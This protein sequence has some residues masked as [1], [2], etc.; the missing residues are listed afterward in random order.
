MTDKYI[1]PDEI[2]TGFNKRG[3]TLNGLLGFMIYRN[4]PDGSYGLEKSFSGWVDKKIPEKFISNNFQT[5][6]VINKGHK[7][8]HYYGNTV[9]IRVYHPEGFEFEIPLDNLAM[10][11]HN[12]TVEKSNIIDKCVVAWYGNNVFLIPEIMKNEV[13]FKNMV[14]AQEKETARKFIP[15]AKCEPAN[16]YETENGVEFNIG[17]I[18]GVLARKVNG[19]IMISPNTG[20]Q[21]SLPVS[22]FDEIDNPMKKLPNLYLK[23]KKLRKVEDTPAVKSYLAM[24]KD[25][26]ERKSSYYYDKKDEDF[27]LRNMA[28]SVFALERGHEDV[29]EENNEVDFYTLVLDACTEYANARHGYSHDSLVMVPKKVKFKGED[30]FLV[31]DSSG[32]QRGSFYIASHQ[33]RYKTE[34]KINHFSYSHHFYRNNV[35]TDTRNFNMYLIKVDRLDMNYFNQNDLT[36]M[37]RVRLLSLNRVRKNFDSELLKDILVQNKIGVDKFLENF[38]IEV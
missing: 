16:L 29:F 19:V 32:Y 28:S 1:A 31:M 21:A 20:M 26:G 23:T 37:S 12:C 35:N 3:D 13:E 18:G 10:I 8:F 38:A 36:F 15:A 34:E 9:K 24:Y 25:I 5:G 11:L 22:Y 17:K 33:E 7:R 2:R 27:S 30:Y 4:K 14:D 6:F